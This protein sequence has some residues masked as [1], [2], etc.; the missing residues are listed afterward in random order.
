M[1]HT[2]PARRIAPDTYAIDSFTT[3]RSYVVDI[4]HHTCSC[5]HWRKRLAGTGEHCKHL[6]AVAAQARF[7]RRME[8]AE[9]LPDADLERLLVRYTEIGD[10][11]TAGAIRRER[12]RRRDA[13]Q[14]DTELLDIFA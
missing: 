4:K 7:L 1:T 9:G 14:A 5:P 11:E 12:Q 10:A 3:D 8:I 6:V 13:L 2:H